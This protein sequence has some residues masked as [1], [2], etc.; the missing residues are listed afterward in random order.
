MKIDKLI[1]GICLVLGI[2]CLGFGV[3]WAGVGSTGANFLLLGGGARP[4]GMGEAYCA[5][6]ND[7]SSMFYNPAG[8]SNVNFNQVLTMYNSWFADITQQMAGAAFPTNLGVVAVGYSG[9]NSGDIQGYDSTG[10]ATSSFTTASSSINLSLGR[11]INSNLALGAG[12]KSIS[13]RLESNRA[14]VMAFDAG[15]KYRFNPQLTVGMSVLNLGSGLK[16]ISEQTPLPTSYRVGAAFATKLFDEDINLDLDV[17]NYTEASKINL[18]AEYVIRNFLFLRLGS[19]GDSLR[20]GLGLAANLFAF[21]YAYLGHQDLGATHQFSISI[22]F[23]APEL[24]K[25]Q[26][27]ESMATGKAYMK[28][29]KY[30]DAILKFQKVISMDSRNEEADIQLRKAQAELEQQ[31][32]E[33]IFA[34]RQVQITR[35][36]SEILESGKNFLSQGKYLEAIAEFG[37]VL[38]LEP[39]NREALKLQNE[40]QDKMTSQL[41]QKSKEESKSFL[42]DAMKNVITGKYNEALTQ[43][44]RALEKDPKNKQAQDLKKKLE[45]ILKIERK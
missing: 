7:V 21:D 12:I 29:E 11:Q 33:K 1:I 26:I 23:G 42:G 5:L 17:V 18:G 13:E 40:A 38:K 19:S 30:S 45:L 20:A 32:F 27:L 39:T 9:L 2:W 10:A 31:A 8:L 22:L 25:K 3:S 4:L 6:A 14:S 28:E 16:F 24:R 34:E 43:V 37:K 35:S 15:L 44:N 41:I 36:A